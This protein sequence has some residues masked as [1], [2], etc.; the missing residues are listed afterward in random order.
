MTPAE[1]IDVEVEDAPFLAVEMAVEGS[2]ETQTLTFRT[3]V[4]DVVDSR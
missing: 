4:D 2:G 1:K 3:N